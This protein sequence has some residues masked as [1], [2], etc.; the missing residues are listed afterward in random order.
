AS[1]E[2]IDLKSYEADM[3]FLID[4][5]IKAEE[6]DKVSPFDDIS[7]LD[8]M[9]AN[10]SEAIESLPKSI[11]GNK[12]AVAETIENNVRSKIVEEHLLDPKY[13]DQMSILLQELIERRKAETISYQEYLLEM[14]N[15]VRQVNQGKKD[16]VP[17]TLNTKGKVAL[18]HTLG[19]ENLALACE[20]AVQYVKKGAFRENRDRKR[21]VKKAI[22]D[23]VKDIN[24]VEEVYKIIEAHKEDY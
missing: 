13:F 1:N 11:K 23:V 8:L 20:D 22:F 4:T 12:E 3:R 15:L 10:M 2:M 21:M 19:D 17:A 14:A 18:Y 7:L 9:G 16:D 6:S 24:K 5:Y